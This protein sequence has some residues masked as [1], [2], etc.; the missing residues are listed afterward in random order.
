[1]WRSY[2]LA[3]TPNNISVNGASMRSGIAISVFYPM[4]WMSHWI[5]ETCGQASKPYDMWNLRT[6]VSSI[7]IY[8][9]S[10][11]S[12]TITQE[13]LVTLLRYALTLRFPCQPGRPSISWT[14]IGK[15]HLLLKRENLHSR[16]WVQRATPYPSP[17]ARQHCSILWWISGSSVYGSVVSRLCSLTSGDHLVFYNWRWWSNEDERYILQSPVEL[18]RCMNCEPSSI[19]L[20]QTT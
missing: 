2:W 1:M 10:E 4:M 18:K 14:I 12:G 20:D 9:P 11:S 13:G 19:E 7:F 16:Q 3:G 5:F 17:S 15:R 8:W 6:V